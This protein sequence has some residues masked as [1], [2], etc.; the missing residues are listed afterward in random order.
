[1][2]FVLRRGF[3]GNTGSISRRLFFS[4]LL[5][6]TGSNVETFFYLNPRKHVNLILK[7]FGDWIAASEGALSPSQLRTDDAQRGFGDA[8]TTREARAL[9]RKLAHTKQFGAAPCRN[10]N[11]GYNSR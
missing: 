2:E 5:N 1:M 11:R 10:G 4:R 6:L 7:F 8:K 3:G 9:P